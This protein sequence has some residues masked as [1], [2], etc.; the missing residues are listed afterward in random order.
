MVQ[1][2]IDPADGIARPWKEFRAFKSN[3]YEQE[4]QAYW[5]TL[6]QK[7]VDPVDGIAYTSREFRSYYRHSAEQE[8]KAYWETLT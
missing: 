5:K 4:I 2:R 6:T 3:V 8:I 7:R 1:R